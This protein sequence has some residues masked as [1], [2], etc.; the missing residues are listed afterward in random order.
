MEFEQN[1]FILEAYFRNGID[2]DGV[3]AYSVEPCLDQFHYDDHCLRQKI[4]RTLERFRGT[5]SV[6]K[7]KSSGR[8]PVAQD[9]EENIRERIEDNPNISLRRLAL[10]SN[11]PLSTCHKVVKKNFKMHA[12]KINVYH[13]LKPQDF[14]ARV[15]YCHWFQQTFDDDLLDL[16]IY[17]DEAWLMLGGYVNSQNFRIWSTD[18]PHAYLKAPL[19]PQK[20]GIWIAVSRRRLI[21][22]IF[23]NNTI[24]GQ[25]CREQILQNFIQQLDENERNYGWFHHD[26]ATSHT[27]QEDLAFL[28]QIFGCLQQY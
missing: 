5:G 12:Y 22:P 6:V 11:V 8:P 13:E 19:Y 26:G 15:N 17:S 27:T 2:N 7:S 25:R 14:E 9:I 1:Q 21:G 16:T 4:K 18:N 23:F 3:W 28:R 10:Q 20:I 24:N